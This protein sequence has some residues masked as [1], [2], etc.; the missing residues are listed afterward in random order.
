MSV[1]CD[2]P[3]RKSKEKGYELRGD[4]TQTHWR[5]KG[6]CYNCH[7]GIIRGEDGTEHHVSFMRGESDAKVHNTANAGNEEKQQSD[8]SKQGDRSPDGHTEREIPPV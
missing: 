2:K 1:R 7:C 8:H 4:G 6:D 5:C 3:M